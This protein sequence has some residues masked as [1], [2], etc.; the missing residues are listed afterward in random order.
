V[1][2]EF[3]WGNLRE[4]DILEDLGLNGMIVL[5]W[6]FK[7]WDEGMDWI[8]LPQE[9]EKWRAILNAVSIKCGEFLVTSQE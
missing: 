7:K 2:T 1:H 3:W 4:R 9:R 5:K 6:I 8:G